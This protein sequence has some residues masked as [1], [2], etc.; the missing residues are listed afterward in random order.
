MYLF[1]CPKKKQWEIEIWRR[2]GK[3]ENPASLT[4]FVSLYLYQYMDVTVQILN[5]TIK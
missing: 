1:E 2:N 5:P 3:I 4:V